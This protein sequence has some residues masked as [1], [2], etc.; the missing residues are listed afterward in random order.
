[1]YVNEDYA[2]SRGFE[3]SLVKRFSHK[4]SGE[5]NYTYS[6]ATGVASDPNQGLQFANG[7]LLYLP[8]S[9]Q[10]L[11]WDQRHT[12]SASMVIRDPSKWGVNVLWTY[13][14][15]PALHADVPQRPQAGPGA[16]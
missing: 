10:P 7:N 2:S 13:G 9:E 6:I 4:F 8:I 12:L 15:G 11:D 3:A 16:R 14:S 1:V 5:I